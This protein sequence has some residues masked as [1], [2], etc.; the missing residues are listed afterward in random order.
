MKITSLTKVL[1][2]VALFGAL[3]MNTQAA[4]ITYAGEVLSATGALATLIT[5][6][7][8]PMGGTI[9]YDDGAIAGG[10]AG[11]GDITSITVNVGAFCFNLDPATCPVGSA[12]VAI[13]SIDAAA[14]TF[15]GGAPT[16]GTLDITTFAST[17]GLFIP[18]S[19][20]LTAGTFLATSGLGNVSGTFGAVAAV[21]VPAA[22]WL[23]GSALL[24][25][26]G[27]G[28]KRKAA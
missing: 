10:L 13:T 5:P 4:E 25:L 28:R 8:Q 6:V 27:V 23:F 7:P 1:S 12:P 14:V 2:A 24:G 11:P 9:T 26:A 15:A 20:D 19:F 17:F 3:S 16:G 22:A 18:I 21:P